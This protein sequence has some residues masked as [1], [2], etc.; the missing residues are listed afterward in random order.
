MTLVPEQPKAFLCKCVCL[1]LPISNVLS[2]TSFQQILPMIFIYSLNFK[3]LHKSLNHSKHP[4]ISSSTKQQISYKEGRGLPLGTF[5]IPKLAS[6]IP[7]GSNKYE[8]L[9]YV[10]TLMSSTSKIRTELGGITPGNPRSP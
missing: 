2:K 1:L 10:S 5:R 6:H 3:V 4:E 8:D 7:Y 9:A